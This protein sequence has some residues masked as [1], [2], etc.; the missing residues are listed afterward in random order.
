MIIELVSSTLQPFLYEKCTWHDFWISC[1]C[2]SLHIRYIISSEWQLHHIIMQACVCTTTLHA[3]MHVH[4]YIYLYR[5]TQASITRTDTC[6]Y[7]NALYPQ[8]PL[9]SQCNICHSLFVAHTPTHVNMLPR[10]CCLDTPNEW[11]NVTHC[12]LSPNTNKVAAL[13]RPL[14]VGLPTSLSLCH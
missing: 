11:H 4:A 3:Y 2:S 5:D 7:I 6:T 1:T 8:L 14:S 10:N 13:G 12:T 9:L